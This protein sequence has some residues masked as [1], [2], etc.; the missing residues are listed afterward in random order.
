MAN[1]PAPRKWNDIQ[2]AIATISMAV[3]LVFWNLFAGP[4]RASAEKR[5]QEQRD[6]AAI[7]LQ[8]TTVTADPIVVVQPTPL[9]D[10][11]ILFGGSAPQTQIIVRSGGGGGG[12]SGGNNG[13][14]PVTSTKSS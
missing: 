5:A 6:Q 9:G 4:D 2:I 10:G 1:K 8:P 13:G 11:K 7:P 3:T 14:S 12:G